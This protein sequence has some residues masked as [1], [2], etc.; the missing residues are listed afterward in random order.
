M[1]KIRKR[2]QMV[3][4]ADNI[5]K[6]TIPTPFAVGPVNLYYFDGETPSLIDTGPSSPETLKMLQ[7]ALSSIGRKLS[8]IEKIFITHGHLDHFGL[9]SKLKELF[10]PEVF[11]HTDDL[12]R[13][14]IDPYTRIEANR[15]NSVAIYKEFGIPAQIVSVILDF[16]KVFYAHAGLVSGAKGFCDG[17]KFLLGDRLLE[18]I[19]CPG[20]SPGA[21]C[22][23]DAGAKAL[24][25]GDHLLKK[26]TPNPLIEMPLSGRQ[27][28]F[29]SLPNYLNS[30][31]KVESLDVEITW[32]GHG[33]E[34]KDIGELC[35]KLRG[36][37]QKRK[38]LILS[39]I[40][41]GDKTI[42]QSVLE[43][44]NNLAPRDVFLGVSEVVA[45]LD[46]LED[47]ARVE[48]IKRNGA[49]YFKKIP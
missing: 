44:F 10:N 38:E 7:E 1:T 3:E 17:D 12:Y 13:L 8:D 16:P 31:E 32:P 49:V 45:H 28:Q 47:E 48:T 43:I 33:E 40:G 11:I 22:F 18:I 20:H 34:I 24:F 30:L 2:R 39:I 19:H 42:Y 41:S 14:L 4:I 26:I 29:K 36:H 6:I 37:H 23:Y 35:E 15:E 25:S 46:L 5:H 21:V 27:R 9:A